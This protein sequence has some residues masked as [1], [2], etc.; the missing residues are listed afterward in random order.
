MLNLDI[1]DLTFSRV[2]YGR[3]ETPMDLRVLLYKGAAK[4]HYGTVFNQIAQGE[5]GNAIV[6]R[7]PLLQKIHEAL[8]A[9]IVA[10]GSKDTAV[11]NF[12]TLREFFAWADNHGHT[13]ELETVETIFRQWADH[14][15]HLVRQ[16]KIKLRSAYL[17]AA[18]MAK[19]LDYV[20]DR[21]HPLIKTIPISPPKLGK[22]SVGVAADKQNLA[23]TFAFGHLCV[24]VIQSLSFDTVFGPLPVKIRLRDGRIFERWLHFVDSAKCKALQPESTGSNTKKSMFRR[25]RFEADRTPRTHHSMINLRILCEMSIFMA[26]TGMNLAQV[27]TLRL[28]QF[29]YKSTIDGYAVRAYKNRRHGEVLFEIFSE[30]KKHFE[31]YLSWRKKVFANEQTDLLF[32]YIRLHGS[33]DSTP[34]G[35]AKLGELCAE[36]GVPF[37]SSRRLRKTRVNWLLRKS[38]DPDLTAEQ[39][40]HTKGVLLGIYEHPSQQVAIAE[41]IQF[42]KKNDPTLVGNPMP[43]PAPGVCDGNPKPIE[44]LPPEAPKA[45]CKHPAGCLFCGHHRDIDSEDYVWSVASMRHLNTLILQRFRPP[46]KG[47]ADAASHV[48][49]TIEMLTAKLKWFKDSNAKRKSWVEEAVEKVA[50]CDFHIHWRYLIESAEGV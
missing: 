28:D 31:H 9:K 49:L 17:K 34:P 26:Q 42:W 41:F 48:Q 11:H 15:L 20:L 45:D 38:R 23:N 22:R 32:P 14:L 39:A 36:V 43:C 21:Q 18:I 29:S 37:I 12:D 40:Q 30:Y 2:E 6:G 1:P 16:S 50:E 33:H 10:G 7:I 4:I 13:L 27:N 5:F 44:S 8:S 3:K 35:F 24:D 25:A 47:K 46:A 19:I